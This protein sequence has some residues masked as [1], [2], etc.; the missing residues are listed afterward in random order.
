M[1]VLNLETLHTI[2]SFCFFAPSLEKRLK[3]AKT[4]E[5]KPCEKHMKLAQKTRVL[6]KILSEK[7]YP[8]RKCN[9]AAPCQYR[10]ENAE[11][12]V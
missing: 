5:N 11:D 4:L 2:L 3:P 9:F 7:F 12:D 6:A 8:I 1:Q 10:K